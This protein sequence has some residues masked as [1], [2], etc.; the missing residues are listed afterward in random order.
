MSS[1]LRE[2]VDE[3]CAPD[4]ATNEGAGEDASED[5]S[6]SVDEGAGEV[7]VEAEA[8]VEVEVAGAGAGEAAGDG[9]GESEGEG[10]NEGE[11]EGGGKSGD[12]GKDEG[13]DK[14][15]GEG[16]TE[17]E[18]KNEGVSTAPHPGSVHA[19]VNALGRVLRVAEAASKRDD[20]GSIIKLTKCLAAAD[21]I[22]KCTEIEKL[23]RNMPSFVIAHR[24]T[25]MLRRSYMR[26]DE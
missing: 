11:N 5:A 8:E 17:G 13:E 12:E 4:T 22:L 21:G 23:L 6:E 14:A 7:K 26:F 15:E 25:C 9:K 18:D 16:K 1:D 24:S 3:L 10:E 2:M 19:W 20:R